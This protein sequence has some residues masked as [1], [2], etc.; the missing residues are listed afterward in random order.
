MEEA[1][2]ELKINMSGVFILI[3]VCVGSVMMISYGYSVGMSALV[4]W[5]FV[6]LLSSILALIPIFSRIFA[7]RVFVEEMRSTEKRKALEERIRMLLKKRGELP[8]EEGEEIEEPE[9]GEVERRLKLILDESLE[10]EG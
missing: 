4:L 5:G 8:E 2:P 7:Y 3:L 9:M 6:L 1:E 10:E